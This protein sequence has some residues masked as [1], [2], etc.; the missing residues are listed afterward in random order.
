[1]EKGKGN[2]NFKMENLK[3]KRKTNLGQA[4]YFVYFPKVPKHYKCVRLLL[5]RREKLFFVTFYKLSNP[6]LIH[7][8][9]YSIY[10]C[11]GIHHIFVLV[12]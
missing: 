4:E 3:K 12:K 11:R 7:Y 2:G 10:L 5:F 9:C 6:Y 8:L 1:M